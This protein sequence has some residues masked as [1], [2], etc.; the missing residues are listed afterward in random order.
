V[1]REAAS[2][3]PKEAPPRELVY[4]AT[5][6][7]LRH[8]STVVTF[9]AF[10]APVIAAVAASMVATPTAGL[11]ALLGT[12]ALVVWW[13]KRKE[14]PDCI[15]LSV[16]GGELVVRRERSIE[17]IGRFTL[18]ELVN[19]SLDSKLIRRVL[20]G[21]SPIPAVRFT[22]T[23]VAPESTTARVILVARERPFVPLGQTYLAHMDATEWLGKIRLFLRKHGW[24]PEDERET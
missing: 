15:I 8:R 11:L 19:V 4:A 22:D 10:S 6:P 3:E 9:Q 1:Y 21:A 20:D 24:V 17:P 14:R 5:D 12:S 2:V 18:D 7:D 23:R 16:D 13:M